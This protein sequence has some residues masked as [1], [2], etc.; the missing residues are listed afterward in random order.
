MVTSGINV[1]IQ[2]H[3]SIPLPVQLAARGECRLQYLRGGRGN[4]GNKR[5]GEM[6]SRIGGSRGKE[7]EAQGIVSN[8]M[9]SR[10][11]E[12]KDKLE[13][14]ME[15]YNRRGMANKE[16]IMEFNVIGCSKSTHL[17]IKW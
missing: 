15:Y 13:L 14:N 7:E 10:G 8:K 17:S 3:N 9:D 16:R 12:R 2:Q 4:G 11:K 1:Q 5:A 6:R